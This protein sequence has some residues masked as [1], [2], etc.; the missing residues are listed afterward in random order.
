MITEASGH[1]EARDVFVLVP[2][3][4]WPHVSSIL[5]FKSLNPPIVGED[6]LFFIRLRSFMVPIQRIANEFL[7]FNSWREWNDI[8]RLMLPR[9]DRSRVSHIRTKDFVA[10]N[11]HWYARGTTEVYI[12]SRIIIEALI[13]LLEALGKCILDFVWI[14]NSLLN[15]C[16]IENTLDSFFHTT[17]EGASHILRH[18][19]SIEAMAIANGKEMSP[20]ILCQVRK[21][22]EAILVDLPWVRWLVTGFRSEC[23]FRNAVIKLVGGLRKRM[24]GCHFSGNRCSQLVVAL[25]RTLMLLYVSCLSCC[26]FWWRS[27]SSVFRMRLLVMNC[28]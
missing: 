22:Q 10:Y 28:C 26:I 14:N 6:S 19:F 25:R 21:S 12:D 24:A 2:Y 4:H 1:G 9:K 8:V 23:K 20:S 13:C 15:F 16:L 17:T 3:A 11:K 7:C 5:V 27:V 18:L